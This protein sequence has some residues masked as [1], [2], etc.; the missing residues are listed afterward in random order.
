VKSTSGNA[1]LDSKTL[2]FSSNSQPDAAKQE[3][4]AFMIQHGLDLIEY[5]E[6]QI[7]TSTEKSA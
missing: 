3:L 6:Y 2:Q 7:R 5:I 1:L 4:T